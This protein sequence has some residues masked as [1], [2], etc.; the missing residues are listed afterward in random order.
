MDEQS[1]DFWAMADRSILQRWP[2]TADGAPEEAVRL[3][4]QS[5]LDSIADITLSLLEGCGIPAFKVGCQGKVILGFAGLGV[6][7]YVPASR[8]EEAQRLLESDVPDEVS[9]SN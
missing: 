2:Q 8:L 1:K 3:T 5:E 6:E 4:R 9:E 7:I